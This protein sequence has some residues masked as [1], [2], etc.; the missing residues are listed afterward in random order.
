[1]EKKVKLLMII[2]TIIIVIIIGI[3]IYL[4]NTQNANNSISI[5][6]EEIYYSDQDLSLIHI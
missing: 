4:L 6:K 3:L 5:G 1:M 2:I